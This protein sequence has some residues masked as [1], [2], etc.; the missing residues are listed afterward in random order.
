MVEQEHMLSTDPRRP[1]YQ[2][3]LKKYIERKKEEYR[4]EIQWRLKSLDEYEQEFCRSFT[5]E[6]ERSPSQILVSIKWTKEKIEYA[7]QCLE[8]FTSSV[9]REKGAPRYTFR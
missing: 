5:G 7:R 2:R 6:P 4:S 8:A 1:T 3:Y 9:P